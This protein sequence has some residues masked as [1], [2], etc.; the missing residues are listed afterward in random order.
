MKILIATDGSSYSKAMIKDFAN[1]PLAS[2]T[3][4]KIITA[5]EGTA[6]MNTS[7]MG[8]MTEF[9]V[10]V[11]TNSSNLAEKIVEKAATVIRNKNPELTIETA[12][13]EGTPKNV[14]LDEAESFGA[15]LIILGSHGYGAIDRFLL[16]SV[17]QSVALHAKCSVEIVRKK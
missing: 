1:R 5:Y 10:A 12:V 8:V 4:V 6:L 2:N 9:Y 11:D 15:D 7:S 13:I 16:G 3:K 14:I 17:S